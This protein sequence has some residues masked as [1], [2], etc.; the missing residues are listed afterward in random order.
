MR[1]EQYR[2]AYLDDDQRGV[3]LGHRVASIEVR[4]ADGSLVE[5]A[6]MEDDAHADGAVVG[7]LWRE[8]VEVQA[9]LGRERTTA[10]RYRR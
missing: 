6:S 8:D 5:P 4:V 3:G 9:V 1:V 10:D 7:L 2:T